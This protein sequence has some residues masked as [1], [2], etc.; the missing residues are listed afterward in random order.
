MQ[1]KIEITKT[2]PD[3][4]LLDSGEGEK[5]ERF[6]KYVL[7]RPDPQALWQKKLSEKEW[8]KCD[9]F[10]ERTA[11]N[12]KWVFQNKEMPKSWQIEFG[13]LSLKIS[14]TAFKHT[15]LFPEQFANW[16]WMTEK[17]GKAKIQNPEIKVL[18]LFG[19]TGGATLACAKAGAL[20]THVDAS[21][22]S[23][24]W[25]RENQELSKLSDCPIRWIL[26]DA[27]AF[28]KKEI[29]R[30]KKYDAILLDPPSFGHGPNGEMWKIEE[31]FLS[32]LSDC[33]ALLSEKPLFFLLNGYSA[34]YSSVGYLNA[35]S[36]LKTR[37]GGVLEH[38]ELVLEEAEGRGLPAGIFARW[39]SF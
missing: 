20:V 39:S 26:D 1:P 29:K 17:I 25:G 18:N 10:F 36:G 9:A 27:H 15:G 12:A 38:G 5:L 4:E 28:V 30:G 35:I 6:G 21:K 16:A 32:L 19:Y 7:R 3:Y 14:P 22:T 2:Q 13:G 34:G 8:E 11:K 31:G 37:F 24:N 23:I 33:E